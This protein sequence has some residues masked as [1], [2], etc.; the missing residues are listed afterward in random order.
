[1][2]SASQVGAFEKFSANRLFDGIERNVLNEIRPQ[3]SLLRVRK[4]DVIYREGDRGDFLYLVGE[5]VVKISQLD[6]L[7]QA[8]T[9]GYVESGNF[10]GGRALLETKPHSA[11]A[12]AAEPALL[13]T[14]KK[15]AFEKMLALAPARL[16]VNFLRAVAE[17]LR[18]INSRFMSDVL[19]S[20]RL[21]VA[22]A[23]ANSILHDLKNPISIAR[24]C[25]DLIAAETSDSELHELA[26][27]LG[28]A[29]NGMVATT[30]DLLDYTHGPIALKKQH[31]S[32]WRVLDELN[33]QSLRLLPGKNIEFIKHIRY[34]GNMDVDLARFVRALCHLIRNACEAMLGGGVLR[35]TTDRVHN[36]VVLRISDSG[37]GIPP[38]LMSTL[39]EPFETASK[40]VGTGLG[41]AIVK[42]IVEAHHGKISIASVPNKGTTIDIRLPAPAEE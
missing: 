25:A 30:Q 14:V 12:T 8:E 42:A 20:E 35:F 2:K 34:D 41:L 4:D 37:V 32:V 19:R 11:M 36:E 5:G 10:F 18:S 9:I 22:G 15:K 29:V 26:T 23:I 40:W 6:R 7:G 13:G 1:M 28:G 24:C 27:L 39:F 16:H 17:R 3:V 38:Q 21:R 33:Q 31:V